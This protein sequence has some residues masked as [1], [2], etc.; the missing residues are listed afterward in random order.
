MSLTSTPADFPTD[1]LNDPYASVWLELWRIEADLNLFDRLIG[2]TAYWPI[3]RA[4]AALGVANALGLHQR[5]PAAIRARRVSRAASSMHAALNG[6]AFWLHSLRADTVLIPSVRKCRNN[7]MLSDSHSDRLL[8]DPDFGNFLVLDS[9]FSNSYYPETATRAVRDWDGFRTWQRL[10]GGLTYRTLYA[11]AMTEHHLLDDHFRRHFARPFP[12]SAK[13]LAQRVAAFEH[14]RTAARRLLTKVGARRVVAVARITA[15]DVIAAARDVGIPT[16]EI[17]HGACSIYDALVHYPQRP[18]VDTAPDLFLTFSPYWNDMVTLP[19]QT[20]AVPVGAPISLAAAIP[21]VPAGTRK[22]VLLSQWTV[23]SRM[24]AL[25]HE[26]AARAPDWRFVFRPHPSSDTAR[27]QRA[28]RAQGPAYSNLTVSDPDTD[29]AD[30][31]ADAEVQI[32]VYSTSLFE[33]MTLGT[34]T[35]VIAFPGHAY[36]NQALKDGDACL[37]SDAES[38]VAMLPRAPTCRNRLRYFSLPTPS[39]LNVINSVCN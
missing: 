36:M 9:H 38:A 22:A 26:M 34:R 11:A 6:Q 15:L 3:L 2:N 32:G 31:L 5:I 17:Q 14:G 16:I 8:A 13:T 29:I 19:S 4:E 39:L 28:V 27:Y 1:E 37:A 35:I 10:I 30:E 12:L 20:K 21:P 23:D 18:F 7:G 24:F 33:G 25:A